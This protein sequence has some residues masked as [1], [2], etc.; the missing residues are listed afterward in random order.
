M[1]SAV[2]HGV[3]K[4]NAGS[5]GS[6]PSEAKSFNDSKRDPSGFRISLLVKLTLAGTIVAAGVTGFRRV[7]RAV[8]LDLKANDLAT[9]TDSWGSIQTENHLETL[10]EEKHKHIEDVQGI[11]YQTVDGIEYE[12]YSVEL[13]SNSVISGLLKRT[14]SALL[15]DRIDVYYNRNL[16]YGKLGPQAGEGYVAF[17]LAHGN[18]NTGQIN[19]SYS[20]VISLEGKIL[21]AAIGKEFT[22][23]GQTYFE[24]YEALKMKN[25]QTI[26]LAGNKVNGFGGYYAWRYGADPAHDISVVP[27][28]LVNASFNGSSHD[29]QYYPELEVYLVINSDLNML[30]CYNSSGAVRWIYTAVEIF[31]ARSIHFNHAQLAKD[32]HGELA[33]YISVRDYN[34]IQKVNFTNARLIWTLGGTDGEFEIT[35]IDGRVYPAGQ[36]HT[37]FNHQHNAEYIGRGKFAM[38]DNGYNG[39]TV[40]DSRMLILTIN[41]KQRTAAITWEWSTG[42]SSKIFGDCD[43]LPSGNVIGSFWPSEVLHEGEDPRKM[44][45]AVGIEV[46]QSGKFAW[47]VGVRGTDQPTKKYD[48]F[49]GEAPIGWAMYSIERFYVQVIIS[50]LTFDQDS[51]Y[52][53]FEVYNTH[54]QQYEMEA[55]CILECADSQLTH[56]FQILPHWQKTVVSMNVKVLRIDTTRQSCSLTVETT[57][58]MDSTTT[59]FEMLNKTDVIQ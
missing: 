9:S 10:R 23:H 59:S 51:E 43:P 17:N 49:D 28:P 16:T 18:F 8:S 30:Y 27:H 12:K 40:R 47:M 7:Q 4:P 20:I 15:P 13:N 34:A 3:S 5:Y 39:S 36:G 21:A 42:V 11:E 52:F 33:V 24:R 14:P 50:G 58:S 37:P 48:R 31:N 22:I 35:D 54:R 53:S 41:E 2:S 46:E 1:M 26:M 55:T 29:I 19:A 57:D 25:T 45:E 6:F 44:Y 38:F 32:D 56:Y